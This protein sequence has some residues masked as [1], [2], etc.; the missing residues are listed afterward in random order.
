[1]EID[2]AGL[3]KIGVAASVGGALVYAGMKASREVAKAE[4]CDEIELV[5]QDMLLVRDATYSPS[6]ELST[7]E[8]N[9]ALHHLDGIQDRLKEA[10]ARNKPKPQQAA[11]KA[12]GL[13]TKFVT[14]PIGSF[15]GWLFKDKDKK[16]EKTEDD[17][18]TE[19]KIKTPVEPA[20]I[21]S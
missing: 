15:V 16:E 11:E 20:T 2:G 5:E 8:R 6:G 9:A 10:K 19:V 13:V 1:M 17:A 21:D 14:K 7:R 18:D 12:T 3:A 4:L